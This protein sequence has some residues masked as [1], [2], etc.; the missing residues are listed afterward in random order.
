MVINSALSALGAVST[1]M[2]LKMRT[3]ADFTIFA[4]NLHLALHS[5][6]LTGSGLLIWPSEPPRLEALHW[7]DIAALFNEAINGIL[8]SLLM[9]QIDSIAKNYAFSA[10]IF[11]TAGMTSVVLR[12]QPPWQFHLGALISVVSMALYA[13]AGAKAPPDGKKSA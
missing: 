5:L 1:E 4:T 11:V 12:Q 8:I 13:R 9:R 7:S 2:A 3:S 6:A 10:S